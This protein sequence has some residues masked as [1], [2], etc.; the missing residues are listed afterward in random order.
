M[1]ERKMNNVTLKRIR[2]HFY[3]GVLA[4]TLLLCLVAVA[5]AVLPGI[6]KEK[7]VSAA[8]SLSLLVTLVC[9][10]FWV[11]H[12]LEIKRLDSVLSKLIWTG[13]I[14]GLIAPIPATLVKPNKGAIRF[15]RAVL[16]N[17]SAVDYPAS[18]NGRPW[19][20]EVTPL[21]SNKLSYKADQPTAIPLLFTVKDFSLDLDSKP[22]VSFSILIKNKTTHYAIAEDFPEPIVSNKIAGD[23][24]MTSQTM[25][26]MRARYSL[27]RDAV[28]VFM[29]LDQ[30]K[31]QVDTP[32]ELLIRVT[33]TDRL[34]GQSVYHDMV[35]T[36]DR[37]K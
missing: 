5:A 25:S 7:Y 34:S 1:K 20:R 23:A 35:A 13:L 16:L 17:P 27:S 10:V 32:G 2:E 36:L 9:V 11:G 19:L 28:G 15:D 26:E 12:H 30:L 29:I 37:P 24:F 31:A 3:Y 8:L 4:L 22:N 21:L 14:A 6:T 18:A 33:A